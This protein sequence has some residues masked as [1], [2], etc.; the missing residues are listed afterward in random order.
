MPP[1]TALMSMTGR[2]FARK[3]MYTR[4][5]TGAKPRQVSRF[6]RNMLFNALTGLEVICGRKQT[7]FMRYLSL[8]S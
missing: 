7:H 6:A 3:P 4:Q 8:D 5:I 2:L 1:A